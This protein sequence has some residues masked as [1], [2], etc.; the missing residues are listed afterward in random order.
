VTGA[1]EA[2]LG[3]GLSVGTPVAVGIG[4]TVIAACLGRLK[5]AVCVALPTLLVAGA[6]NVLAW[7]LGRDG[8]TSETALP[9][10][11]PTLTPTPTPTLTP[12]GGAAHHSAA[13]ATTGTTVGGAH[14]PPIISWPSVVLIGIIFVLL[15]GGGVAQAVRARR[16]AA[17][18]PPRASQS[19]V[20]YPDLPDDLDESFDEILD[21]VDAPTPPPGRQAAVAA[22][23]RWR[24]PGAAHAHLGP[25]C[26][27][28]GRV[29]R[30]CDRMS[31]LRGEFLTSVVPRP[32][33]PARIDLRAPG[34]A[35]FVDA[36]V[37]A[38]DL[39]VAAGQQDPPNQLAD[40]VREAERRWSVVRGHPCGRR[41]CPLRRG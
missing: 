20:V 22:T 37:A 2:G 17:D 6:A 24:R 4:V 33:R 29:N 27:N 10:S 35:W 41:D 28:R 38:A 13:A 5:L 15:V 39:L 40:A 21:R 32:G 36:F 19:P 8:R 30:L 12:G 9:T 34:T 31:W 26:W 14:V 16:E 18:S 23:P 25:D 3:S 7:L 11:T 1:I